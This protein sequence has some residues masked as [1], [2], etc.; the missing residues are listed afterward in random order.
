MKKSTK[1]TS[2]NKV[3]TPRGARHASRKT[4]PV[5]IDLKA[6]EVA[7]TKATAARKSEAAPKGASRDARTSSTPK[8]PP[9]E[10]RAVPGTQ[11]ST[12]SSSS[13]FR[14]S[15]ST[16]TDKSSTPVF[17]SKKEKAPPSPPSRPSP[18]PSS[19]KG[20]RQND[21]IGYFAAAIIGGC[22]AIG[23]AGLL[24]YVGLLGSPAD[25]G[26]AAIQQELN[27]QIEQ[28]K[29][30]IDDTALNARI[31]EQVKQRVNQSQANAI[32]AEIDEII[33]QLNE[34]TLRVE[35]LQTSQQETAESMANIQAAIKAGGAGSGAAVAALGLEVD[36]LA[37]QSEKIRD[38]VKQLQSSLAQL[39][40]PDQALNQNAIS[41]LIT[42]LSALEGQVVK[43]SP[44]SSALNELQSG[45][46][47][48]SQSLKQQSEVII[49]LKAKQDLPNQAE[50]LAAR[51]V[52]AAALKDGIDRGLPFADSLNILKKL[53]A[54]DASLARLDKY[55]AIG[56]PT[57]S[58]LSASFQSASEAII[59]ATDPKPDN[60]LT[61]RLLAG[62]KSFVKVKARKP[63]EGTTPFAIVSQMSE[64]LK[65]DDLA[66]ASSLWKSLPEA[67]QTA[68][69]EWQDQLQS[70][71]IADELISNSVQSFLQ[72]TATQ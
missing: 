12:S 53:S 23:G 22:V 30:R 21:R 39:A 9:R 7:E 40:N 57:S 49:Q 25:V 52:A 56:I 36:N 72:S 34:T 26:V 28:L 66:A 33:T 18:P 45:L 32:P 54:E 71:I 35:K 67:G 62:V 46:A 17:E 47:S 1:S 60:D 10:N 68:S 20:R 59:S 50:K 27:G 4:K 41:E 5:T 44:L 19:P 58:Q 65:N 70:R 42:R 51:S 24:Q 3:Q 2:A 6:E 64:A 16:S 13:D 48:T 37:S 15:G 43:L 8:V 38:N 29:S 63:V 69:S 14:H 61:S 31:A 55:A 11:K